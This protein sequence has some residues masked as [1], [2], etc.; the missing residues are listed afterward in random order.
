MIGLPDGLEK[1]N[2]KQWVED[3]SCPEWRDGFLVAGGTKIP[4]FQRPGLRGDAWFDKDKEYS[5]D[6]QAGAVFLSLR[7]Y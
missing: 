5:M 4:F 7:T 3:E 2:A 6:M 1:E